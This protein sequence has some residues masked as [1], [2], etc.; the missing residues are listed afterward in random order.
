MGTVE[1]GFV[2][3]PHNFHCLDS[4]LHQGEARRRV[5]AMV[6][7]FF[8]VPTGTDSKLE[9]SVAEAIEARDLFGRDDR[10]ALDDQADAGADLDLRG[11]GGS[12]AQRHER[13]IGAV[14]VTG[15]FRP[16]RPRRRSTGWNVG[17]LGKPEAVESARLGLSGQ[18]RRVN[19]FVGRED[20][21]ANFHSPIM[22]LGR[23][24]RQA[25]SCRADRARVWRTA[26]YRF[27]V[28][29]FRRQSSW[30]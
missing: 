1:L 11:D 26:V 9:A 25:E 6:R 17:V 3:G 12:D 29:T 5:R 24:L 27:D 4:L 15:Q 28:S 30:R 7:H 20:E 18:R 22:T 8:E 2:V 13:V 14:V 16:A 19:R 21:N 10:V 23:A